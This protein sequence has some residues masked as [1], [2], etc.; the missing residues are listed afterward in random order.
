MPKRRV[1]VLLHDASSASGSAFANGRGAVGRTCCMRVAC[2]ADGRNSGAA[3]CREAA[4]P[5][6]RRQANH[7]TET[8]AEM[9]MEAAM[10]FRATS[11][12]SFPLRSSSFSCVSLSISL[13]SSS[14]SCV[15]LS[16][17]RASAAGSLY[18]ASQAAQMLSAKRSICCWHSCAA[19]PRLRVQFDNS[20]A[21]ARFAVRHSAKPSLHIDNIADSCERLSPHCLRLPVHW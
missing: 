16:L 9:I 15:S 11:K 19:W 3:S 18:F 4:R 10:A 2:C 13:R 17:A 20:A 6:Q 12:A 14:L 5:R 8:T 21:T 1:R 7:M